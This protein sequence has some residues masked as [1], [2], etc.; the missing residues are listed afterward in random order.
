MKTG[1]TWTIDTNIIVQW[2]ML[3]QIMPFA[4][5]KFNLTQEFLATY[6]SRYYSSI[7]FINRVLELPEKEQQFF[8]IEI[9]LNELFS[10]IRDEIRTIMLFVKGVPISR[11]AYKRETKEVSFPTELSRKIYELT[12]QGFD[13]LFVSKKIGIIPAT[14]PS[15]N[16]D[17]FEVYS[18]LILNPSQSR[19]KNS[20]C[21]TY[22]NCNIR[23]N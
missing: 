1:K 8:V 10:G 22:Y 16:P 19:A 2:L 12:S 3:K 6:E 17:Y 14:V 5:K 23:E 21:D 18:S 15:D 13:I 4:I 9:S 20:R 11:W 7:G